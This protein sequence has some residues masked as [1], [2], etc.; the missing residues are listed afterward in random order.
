MYLSRIRLR[1]EIGA[2]QLHHL[3][4]DRKGYGL[5][6]LF[7]GLFSDSQSNRRRDFLFREERAVE[8]LPYSGKR[9]ADPIYY[10]L[11]P[12]RPKANALFHVESKP[13]RPALSV[14]DRLSFKLRVNAVVQRDGKR[15]D[16]VMDAQ[17]KWLND[18]LQA[19]GQSLTGKKSAR[20][21]RLL[22]HADD[23]QLEQWRSVINAGRY[24]QK[25]AQRTDRLALMEW[26]IKT[27][28]SNRVWQWWERQGRE[29][30]GF[31]IA[32]HPDQGGPMLDYAAY[33]HHPIPEKGRSAGFSTLDLSGEVLVSD[34]DLFTNM[35]M[36]GIGPAKAFGCGL[37]MVRR[38]NA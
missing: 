14:G 7:W 24:C 25:L 32:Q 30:H 13:Y 8:Q 2:T 3:L 29:R 15:H 37:M 22:D 4:N 23:L 16:I 6:R 17:H 38:S 34:A 20:K 36:E 31:N 27:A 9:K 10:V 26:A 19:I 1:P 12:H 18:Q 28:E 11:S 5:H 33:L 35:L 21:Q